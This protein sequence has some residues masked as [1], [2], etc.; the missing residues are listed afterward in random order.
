MYEVLASEEVYAGRVISLR[1]DTVAMPGGGSSV[2]EVVT[3]PG[4]VGVLALDDDGSVVMLKQ[5][6]HAVREHLWELPAGLRDAEGEP[7]LETAKRELAEEAALAADRWQL[8]TTSLSTPGFC[9][10]VVGLYLAEGLH[11]VD[12]PE[13]FVV[14]HEEADMTIERVPL[15]RALQMVFDGTVR[16]ALAVI[17]ILAVTA[18]RSAS[19]QLRPVDTGF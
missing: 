6:R 12:R 14:E 15:D 3:H 5:Y 11:P 1:T 9:D 8:L 4:A 7:P 17:G 2:R 16:N 10:E 18:H 19:P 13:G